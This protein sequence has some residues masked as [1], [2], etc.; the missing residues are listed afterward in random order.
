M[1]I[2]GV[3]QAS[4]LV[5]IHERLEYG[6]G[7]GDELNHDSRHTLYEEF[8]FIV[9]SFLVDLYLISVTVVPAEDMVVLARPNG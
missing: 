7:M 3:F 5:H 8:P 6:G 1:W 2:S 9:H 4:P